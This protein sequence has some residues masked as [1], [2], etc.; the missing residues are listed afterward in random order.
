MRY[1]HPYYLT[2]DNEWIREAI[3]KLFAELDAY[4]AKWAKFVELKGE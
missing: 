2:L 3:E 4:L 1:L